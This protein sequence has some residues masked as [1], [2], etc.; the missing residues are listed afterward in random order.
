MGSCFKNNCRTRP[1]KL[2]S[3][4]MRNMSNSPNQENIE[5]TMTPSLVTTLPLPPPPPNHIPTTER[6]TSVFFNTST[7]PPPPPPHFPQPPQYTP[8]NQ[9]F[10]Y[11]PQYPYQPHTP[12]P[13]PWDYHYYPNPP[14]HVP[15]IS[16]T[17]THFWEGGHGAHP[18][19]YHQPYNPYYHQEPF[20]PPHHHQYNPEPHHPHYE[21]RPHYADPAKRSRNVDFPTFEGDYLESWI[22]KAEKYFSL[23]QTPEEDKVLLAEVHISGRADQWIESLAI[24]TASLSWPE[25]KTMLCQRFAAKSKIEITETFR[26]LKQYGSVDS[27]IDKFEDTMTLVKRSNPTLTKDYFLD[28]FISGLK[29]NIKR[30]LKSLSIYSLVTAYEHAR[31]YDVIPRSANTSSVPSNRKTP[32]IPPKQPIKDN[33]QSAVTHTKFSG[34]YFRCNEPWVPGHGRVCKA[35]KQ[36]YLVTMEDE[37][38]ILDDAAYSTPD[39]PQKTDQQDT[40]L[41]LHSLEGTTPAATTFT[42][43]V[44]LGTT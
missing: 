40:H 9:F 10:P 11:Q 30:P 31:N 7:I 44:L 24:A 20:H 37:S 34:K 14:P 2:K 18:E 4:K 6:N 27:Y 15:P 12:F 1:Y 28:Y 8:L 41:L 13:V 33:K 42:L 35:T 17:P 43:Y 26:N 23:Y 16:S 39:S 5:M 38:E 19:P 36:V 25:F 3:T 22:R 29:D 32:K 21:H